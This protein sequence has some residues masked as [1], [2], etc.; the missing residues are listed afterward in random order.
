MLRSLRHFEKKVRA[1][2]LAELALRIGGPTVVSDLSKVTEDQR[3][4]TLLDLLNS[5]SDSGTKNNVQ[6]EVLQEIIQ[7]LGLTEGHDFKNAKTLI[8]NLIGKEIRDV[9]IGSAQIGAVR[10]RLGQKGMLPP[11]SYKVSFTDEFS[12]L[13]QTLGVTRKEVRQVISAPDMFKHFLPEIS[14]NNEA[15][16]LYVKGFADKSDPYSLLVDTHRVADEVRVIYAFRVFHSDIDMSDISTP[17]DL[18]K[19]FTERFGEDVVFEDEVAKLFLYR[20]LPVGSNDWKVRLPHS[21]KPT[22]FRASQRLMA[23]GV[24]EVAI[25]YAVGLTEY[26]ASLRGH[27]VSITR[28][29]L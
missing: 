2:F 1:D 7:R 20:A 23:S 21:S 11:S 19:A 14:I 22:D 9:T 3:S 6:L 27:G 24:T 12:E 10:K 4:E 15:I 29:G 8:L 25:A 17:L 13:C 5:L 18:L 16:S 28:P 26:V